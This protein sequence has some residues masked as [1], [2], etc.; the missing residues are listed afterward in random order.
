MG[1]WIALFM[2]LKKE[3]DANIQQLENNLNIC[4]T[5]KMKYFVGI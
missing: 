5:H 1:K 2:I 4:K 3:N